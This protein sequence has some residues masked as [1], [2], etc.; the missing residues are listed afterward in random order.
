MPE[1]ILILG[2]TG[3]SKSEVISNLRDYA[4]SMSF[5]LK[6]TCIDFEKDCIIGKNPRLRMRTYLDADSKRQSTHW[7][8]GW[9]CIGPICKEKQDE[10]ILLCM[11]GV[12]TRRTTGTISPIIIRSI[13]EFSPSRIITLIDDV[14]LKWHRTETRAMNTEYVGR[15]TLEQLLDASRKEIFLGEL[16]A[17]NLKTPVEHFLLPVNHPARNLFRLL[18]VPESEIITIYLSFPIS[19]PRKLLADGDN[20]GVEEVNGFLR[21]ANNFESRNSKIVCFYPLCIDELPLLSATEEMKD[22]IKHRIFNLSDRWNTREFF[23]SEQM[24]INYSDFPETISIPSIQVDYAEGFIRR[25]VALRDYTLVT[26]SSFLAVFNPWYKDTETSG[27]RNEIQ[28]ALRHLIPCH[29]YQD[30]RHDTEN[31]AEQTLKP[32]IGTLGALPLSEY[33]TFHS[34]V[35]NVFKP[36]LE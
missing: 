10:I 27:V 2:T 33:I 36:M 16:I 32:Q 1:R 12:L 19:R 35:E 20:S 34:D 5:P 6:F 21:V 25:D 17:K 3:V 9:E 18:F 31:K 28:L 29:I 7:K 4:Q 24:L 8:L 30:P 22:G 13:D 26:Q 23:N 15:P 11:H 14:Y